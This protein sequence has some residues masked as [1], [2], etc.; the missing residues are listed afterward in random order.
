[1]IIPVVGLLVILLPMV[2]GGRLIRLARVRLRAVGVL[3]CSLVAQIVIIE[4]LTGPQAVLTAVHIATYAGA[5]WFL[6]ANRRVPGLLVVAA[7]ALSNGVAIAANG[8]VLPASPHALAV[9]GMADSDGFTNSGIVH[10]ARLW[11][12]GDVFAIPA[13]W[14]LANVFSVGDLLILLGAALASVRICGT[15][16]SSPWTVGRRHAVPRHRRNWGDQPIV[17]SGGG[18]ARDLAGTAGR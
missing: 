8:G 15:R 4:L 17:Q 11:Y 9:A 1:M 7:G 16:W 14:P 6:W 13:G 3:T 10:D 18:P 5:G 12:L 2:L